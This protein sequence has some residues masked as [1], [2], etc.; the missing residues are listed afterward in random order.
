MTLW[1]PHL[2]GPLGW[3]EDFL[4]GHWPEGDEDAMRRTAEHWSNMANA[5]REL[6]RPA[7]Q[8]MNT[9]LSAIDGKIHDAMS[10]Y[11]QDVA[12]GDGS[13]LQGLI[14]ACD[15][16]AK[17]LEHGATDIEY[18]KLSIY[19]SLAAMLAIAFV[20]GIGG[21]VDAAAAKAV[22]L[23]IRKTVQQLIDK[24]AVKGAAF[25]AERVGVEAASRLGANA[26]SELAFK[27]GTE[28]AGGAA[29][30]SAFGAGTDLAA[31]GVQIAEGNRD[32]V[33]LGSVGRAA[34]AGA[35]AG[36]VAGPIAAKAGQS[37]ASTLGTDLGSNSLSGVLT[38]AVGAVPG[39]VAGNTAAAA[40]ESGGH[41]DFSTVADGAGAGFGRA[42]P[43]EVVPTHAETGS[44]A[45]THIESPPTASASTPATQT[46]TDTAPSSNTTPSE[47]STSSA[48]ATTTEVQDTPGPTSASA[49]SQNNPTA[50]QPNS[51]SAG[52]SVDARFLSSDS[53]AAP[54]GSTGGHS[55]L[56]RAPVGQAPSAATTPAPDRQIVQGPGAPASNAAPLG[57]DRPVP[58]NT[59]RT[60]T[61][62]PQRP[63]GAPRSE[64]PAPT[65]R[66][67]TSHRPTETS[68]SPSGLDTPERTSATPP[69]RE[70]TSNTTRL[71]S[72]RISPL[73]G[74]LPT[75]PVTGHRTRTQQPAD[76]I[77]TCRVR[78]TPPPCH[79]R[80]QTRSIRAAR[81]R[82][83]AAGQ[84]ML[85][86]KCEKTWPQ[87]GVVA[88]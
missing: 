77:V 13:D 20:P 56:D 86:A 16:F 57:G 45:G 68:R 21:L 46:P 1:F 59:A 7:D 32:G 27:V 70:T 9:A 34:G 17:Q 74:Y 62:I 71:D 48:G 49:A 80:P 50:P 25:L 30:G 82:D 88:S 2:P 40:A 84:I 43:H 61:D 78:V 6:E 35:V 42:K 87:N 10:T 44:L 4:I 8:A 18:A 58:A 47:A 24:L 66:G 22:Q 55:T 19:F 31:Q 52:N 29:F 28:A 72:S 23:V 38:R 69:A 15:S 11:W 51:T 83:N 5:L 41:V 12:G 76:L 54:S 65:D 53:S 26:A 37:L 39:N 79:E 75:G 63:E 64:T 67:P 85:R 33:D 81:T 36:A 73:T 14:N 3:L 60:S